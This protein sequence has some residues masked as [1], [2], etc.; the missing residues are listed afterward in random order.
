MKLM[1]KMGVAWGAALL[2][3]SPALSAQ[4]FLTGYFLPGNAFAFRM[5]PAFQNE[6][7]SFSLVLGDIGAGVQS[8]LGVSSVLYP[9]QERLYTFLNKVIP[10]ETFMSGLK[11]S[12][13]VSVDLQVDVLTLGF[14]D[15]RNFWTVDI[16]VRSANGIILPREGFRL[17]KE[18]TVSD[19]RFDLSGTSLRSGTYL[20][21]AVGMSHSFENGLNVGA[22]VKAL[23][24]LM[25]MDARF[26]QLDIELSGEQ[27]N[28]KA[29]GKAALS[30]P[31]FSVSPSY[32]GGA[33]SLDQVAFDASRLAPCGYG[34][35]LDA[36]FSWD[37]LPFLTVSGALLDLGGIRW[38][39]EIT[40]SGQETAITWNP[41]EK[42]PLSFP[43][44]E[45]SWQEDFSELQD[46]MKGEFFYLENEGKPAFQMLPFRM[47]LGAQARVPSYDRLS[48]GLL[49]TLR[50]G[51][52]YGWNEGRVSLNW[53]PFDLLSLSGSASA[54]SFGES[55]GAAISFHPG[56]IHLFVGTDF[57]FFHGVNISPLL[58]DVPPS[59]QKYLVLPRGPLN[60]DLRV[61]LSL[62][63]GHRRLDYK[64]SY[65]L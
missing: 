30:S 19:T 45:A 61:G 48:L 24:G 10:A 20:E 16:N 25:E 36:G 35:A 34:A 55:L 65:I 53:T 23:V 46:L 9:V 12:N 3:L 13:P 62:S 22:R 11:Q 42:E 37:I 29:N 47:H 6:R 21:A 40:A 50:S 26:R 4:E 39:R 51:N 58:D 64:R 33:F 57:L 7:N 60:L 31:A 56:G 41:S 63:L 17:L 8:P 38:N 5:N 49:Y 54:H 32:N 52:G 18:G 27:W 2:L 44:D 59:L 1:K 28:V 15:H 14:W 43:P